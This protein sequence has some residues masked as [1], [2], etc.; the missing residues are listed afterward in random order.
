MALEE[1]EKMRTVKNSAG[2]V[3]IEKKD[4]RTSRLLDGVVQYLTYLPDNQWFI[5]KT[6][7][8]IEIPKMNLKESMNRH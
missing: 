2:I 8:T 3:N 7:R 6:H 4:T 1:E 5:D